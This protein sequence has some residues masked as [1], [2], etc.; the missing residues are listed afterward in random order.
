MKLITKLVCL[1]GA[2]LAL[3]VVVAITS[4]T[5]LKKV[6]REIVHVAEES[7]PLMHLISLITATQLEQAILLERGIIAGELNEQA[8]LAALISQFSTLAREVS[9]QIKRATELCRGVL[10]KA[11]SDEVGNAYQSL[12]S[13]LSAIDVQHTTL[14]NRGREILGFM[15]AGRIQEAEAMIH[16]TEE[17]EDALIKALHALLEQISHFTGKTAIKAEA[18]ERQAVRTVSIIMVISILIALVLSLVMARGM[19]IQLG[20]DP[21][22]LSRVADKLARGRLMHITDTATTGIQRAINETI[23]KLRQVISAIEV[24]ASEVSIA[25]EEVSR[26][27]AN[28]SQRTQEQ[29]ATLEEVASSMEEMT[30]TVSQNAGS[31]QQAN[32]RALIAREQADRG[33]D[34]VGR[35][36]DAMA[37]IHTANKKIADIIGVIDDIAFKT[38]L[39]ALNAAVEAARAGEQGRG[40]AV[41]AG[42][43]RNLAGRSAASAKEIRRLIEDSVVKV[44]DGG[45]LAG[46]SGEAL[47]DIVLSVKAVS[48]IVAEIAAASEEQSQGIEQVNKAI[49]QIDD[50]TQQNAALVEQATAAAENMD[51]QAQEL[52]A[53]V[54]F[55]DLGEDGEPIS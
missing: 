39:L 6:E 42:E 14:N 13:A 48:D 45:R 30:A 47:R 4:L 53:L 16:P 8:Q 27:N 40:F 19:L 46:R 5:S 21:G 11:P 18:L 43:V 23:K 1:V 36:V 10:D 35:T 38:N 3:N 49:S 55:F 44:E 20:A 51:A 50:M 37:G 34:A 29:A 54:A 17:L 25:S 41:V 2:I 12:L 7:I 52:N 33:S 31:A 15:Q 32:Q 24:A 9:Q 28:L 22:E 26:G